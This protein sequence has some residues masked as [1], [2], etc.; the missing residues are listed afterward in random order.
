MRN[1]CD[2]EWIDLYPESVY[3]SY[4]DVSMAFLPCHESKHKVI[5][6][7]LKREEF[8]VSLLKARFPN[9]EV[10]LI[11]ILDTDLHDLQLAWISKQKRDKRDI[12]DQLLHIELSF[13][14]NSDT[15]NFLNKSVTTEA[16]KS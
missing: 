11:L 15:E 9:L 13:A 5:P 14:S 4:H 16:G 2:Q 3:H 7:I 8:H 10:W 1:E 12:M 6:K